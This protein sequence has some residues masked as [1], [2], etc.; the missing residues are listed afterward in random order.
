MKALYN[1]R[2]E[3]IALRDDDDLFTLFGE[4]LGCYERSVEVFITCDG[5]YLGEVIEGNYF[6]R[7]RRS[8][9]QDTTFPAPGRVERMSHYGRLSPATEIALP[10]GYQDVDRLS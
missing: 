5:D 4:F 10:N 3:P 1:S 7:H 2:G 6:V 8:P 9:H